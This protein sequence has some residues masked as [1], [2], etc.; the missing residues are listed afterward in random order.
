MSRERVLWGILLLLITGLAGCAEVT[1]VAATVGQATGYLSH[2]DGEAVKRLADQTAKAV[3]PMTDREEYY[4]GRAVAATL[5]SR[6][7][8]YLDGPVIQYVN[9]IGQTTAL[10][11]DHPYTYRGYHFAILDTEEVNALACPGGMIFLTSGMLKKAKNEEQLAASLAHEIAHVNRK[12][13]LESIQKARWTQVVTLLGTEAARKFSGAELAQL[14]SLLE[15]SANDVVATLVVKG[16]SREQESTADRSAL[17][18]LHRAGYDPQGLT[19]FLSNLAH[20]QVGCA[21]QGIFSTHPGMNERLS[22]V[23]SV[24]AEKNW[25]LCDYSIRDRRFLEFCRSR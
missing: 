18:F 5:L 3:R 11:S 6:Y 9:H 2:E 8:L 19:S 4:L 23:E 17:T 21:N 20:E 10:A 22:K 14:V 15:G 13:G 25:P 24:I 7:R 16:Y 12:D 1:K